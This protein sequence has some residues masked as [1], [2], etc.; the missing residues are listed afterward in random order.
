MVACSWKKKNTSSWTIGHF[1]GN[2]T[3]NI[4]HV[5]L[6]AN[7]TEC[8]GLS[9]SQLPLE[10]VHADTLLTARTHTVSRNHSSFH[11]S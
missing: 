7:W 3:A 4:N 9:M 1:L 10:L 11:V 6:S 8:H 5:T 2:G